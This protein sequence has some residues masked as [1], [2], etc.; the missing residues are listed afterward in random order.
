[1]SDARG[2]AADA[3]SLDTFPRLLMQHAR[4][5]PSRPA[6]REKEYG[7]WQTYTWAE[8]A[9][10]VRAIA[11][12]L[13]ALGFRR[14]DR[15]AVVGDNRPR[16][17]WSVAACQ[18]L[19]GIPVMMYQDAVAQEMA[20]VLQD[21]EIKFAIVEDQEQVDKM[22]RYLTSPGIPMSLG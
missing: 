1:M 11:G 20:Y 18:C 3:A 8:V 17:Y 19:G 16:L 7:I 22:P 13:A 14:G 5:R 15:L 4:Q 10:K 2:T 6:M 9:D 12:G 21:A